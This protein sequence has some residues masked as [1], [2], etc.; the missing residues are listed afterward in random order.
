MS[1]SQLEYSEDPDKESRIKPIGNPT[2]WD[3]KQIPVGSE[4]VFI[5]IHPEDNQPAVESFDFGQEEFDELF[6]EEYK[7]A[8]PIGVDVVLYLAP[9]A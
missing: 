8:D 6:N 3:M 5:R 7:D 1:P 9:D 2:I 4:I